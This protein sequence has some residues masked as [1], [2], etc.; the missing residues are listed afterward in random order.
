MQT[1]LSVIVR[2]PGLLTFVVLDALGRRQLTLTWDGRILATPLSPPG[3]DERYSQYMLVALFL[4]YS[5][6]G[7]WLAGRGDWAVTE[8]T[9]QKSLRHRGRDIVKLEY[10]GAEADL[11]GKPQQVRTVTFSHSPIRLEVMDLSRAEL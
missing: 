2:Q 10:K 7:K 9:G 8:G 5:E 6:P 1:F 11:D 3:W 4:H